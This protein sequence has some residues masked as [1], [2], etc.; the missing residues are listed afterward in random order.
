MRK[1]ILFFLILQTSMCAG[2]EIKKNK[3]F[4]AIK[5]KN[6]NIFTGWEDYKSLLAPRGR[7]FAD[8][9]LF[10]YNG[11]NYMFY[12]DY[13][14]NKG[15]IA[16]VTIDKDLNIS[17]PIK[18]LELDIHLSFPYVF[19]EEGRIY[20]I[21]ET[22]RYGEIALYEALDFPLNW[23]K[24]RVL[25][26]GSDYGDTIL[27]KYDDYY[28]LITSDNGTILRIFY[29][30]DLSSDFLPHPINLKRLQGRNA[31]GVFAF[32]GHL[33]R[34][35]M[36]CR[37]YYGRAVIFKKIISL[38]PT[39]FIEKEVGRMEPTWAPDLEG[40]HT[41]S[42]NEDLVVYDGR[43]KINHEEDVFYSSPDE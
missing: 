43:R 18:V 36:D 42:V 26:K 30:K 27:F 11:L 35:V 8:P 32:G 34:P 29:A 31:G 22:H 38:T 21:P 15:I 24:K 4:I 12:E 41:F 17:Q 13:D 14:Y 20:M 10:K 2:E 6:E 23:C 16:C 25:V 3:Y 33:I 5:S 1:C 40:T 39:E 37:P 7:F 28:W 19:E 9:M